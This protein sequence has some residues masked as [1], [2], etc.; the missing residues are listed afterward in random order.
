MIMPPSLND[1]EFCSIMQLTHWHSLLLACLNFHELVLFHFVSVYPRVSGFWQ[2]LQNL[3]LHIDSSNP[4]FSKT[5]WRSLFRFLG[6]ISGQAESFRPPG[7]KTPPHVPCLL[8]EKNRTK[9]WNL[10][11]LTEPQNNNVI[12]YDSGQQRH[13]VSVWWTFLNF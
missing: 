8:S 4:N 9:N 7:I 13:K 11:G 10:P 6:I 2:D 5:Q 1:V 3:I 12:V